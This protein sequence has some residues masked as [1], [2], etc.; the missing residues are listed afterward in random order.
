M[1]AVLVLAAWLGASALA[2]ADDDEAGRSRWTISAELSGV[3]V[4]SNP[5]Y[6]V[7]T[8]TGVGIGVSI[9]DRLGLEAQFG[10]YAM[11]AK[12]DLHASNTIGQLKTSAVMVRLRLP[13][14]P[15]TVG[16]GLG[17]SRVP[18]LARGD[19]GRVTTTSARQ[20]GAWATGALL[21]VR[22]TKMSVYAEGRMFLP[23]FKE[24]PPT[25]YPEQGGDATYPSIDSKAY[26]IFTVG[27]GV[28]FAL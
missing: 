19:D 17:Q 23:L 26:P 7:G 28:R 27:L 14:L 24:I 11:R 10:S 6:A 16:G 5:A 22:S 8:G 21:L 20:M 4:A 1:R 18:L 2:H 25:H 9:A 3:A 15:L 12:D 13:L